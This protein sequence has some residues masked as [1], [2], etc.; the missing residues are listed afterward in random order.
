MTT[1]KLFQTKSIAA[2]GM[3]SPEVEETMRQLG[4]DAYFTK[5]VDRNERTARIEAFT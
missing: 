4:A 5:P 2:I 1:G 3:G